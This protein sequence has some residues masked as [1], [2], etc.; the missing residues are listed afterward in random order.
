MYTFVTLDRLRAR[1]GLAAADTAE[2]PRLLAALGAASAAIE[3]TL[4]RRFVPRRAA[5]THPVNPRYA[6]ELLLG[7]DLL[8][9]DSVSDASGTLPPADMLLLP[10]APPYS[11]LR[12]LNWRAFAWDQSP[13]RAVTVSGVWGWHDDWTQAWRS[14]GDS[15]QNAPLSASATSLSVLDADG[16]DA[17]GESP[18]FQV[19]HLLRAGSE[20]LRVLAVNTATNTLTVQRGVQGSSAA[21]HTQ[22]TPLAVY[23]PPED[24]AMLCLRWA[25]WLYRE[26]DNAE[27]PLLPA[28]LLRG[29][30]ALR[31][32]GVKA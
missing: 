30:D 15:V 25:V 9:L 14:S 8:E 12:L 17:A 5:V 22:G 6:S 32:V 18:R 16:E 19:G 13:Y 21:E 1:L 24:V 29:L 26:A 23:Q 10:D 28:R 20:Y 27:T 3:R 2:N 7:D 31:R 4:G 11:M